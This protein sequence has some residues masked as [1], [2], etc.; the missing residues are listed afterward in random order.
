FQNCSACDLGYQLGNAIGGAYLRFEVNASRES[1][2]RFGVHPECTRSVSNRRRVEVSAFDQD[3]GRSFV[4]FGVRAAHHPGNGDRTIRVG[5]DQHL[6]GK[7]SLEAVERRNTLAR[8]RTPND[9][10]MAVQQIQ[11]EGVSGLP[12]LEHHVVGYVGDVVDRA[13]SYRLEPL[14]EPF[15]RRRDLHTLNNPRGVSGTQVRIENLDGGCRF[16]IRSAFIQRD[17]TMNQRSAA[18]KRGFSRDAEM[19]KRVG[20]IRSQ[21]EIEDVIVADGLDAFDRETRHRQPLGQF[22]WIQRERHKLAQPLIT[23]LHRLSP[24]SK[25]ARILA[26]ARTRR[27]RSAFRLVA[28]AR[29]RAIYNNDEHYPDKRRGIARNNITRIM[30]AKINTRNSDSQ[31][32]D[33]R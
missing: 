25:K 1:V 19:R 28:F 20:A 22:F 3:V 4:D 26:A 27:Q 16:G 21:I 17:R 5:D 13:L 14:G 10:A 8:P 15:R 24:A 29:N 18:H 7:L 12:H 6:W 9:D 2:R 31:Y 30:H 11:I 32:K 33:A 23:D